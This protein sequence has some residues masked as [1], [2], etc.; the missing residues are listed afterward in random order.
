MKNIGYCKYLRYSIGGRDVFVLFS[1]QQ[2][3]AD[4]TKDL[5][6]SEPVS[7]GMMGIVFGEPSFQLGS[8]TLKMAGDP[9]DKDKFKNMMK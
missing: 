4:I 9:E 6:K 3:H 2:Q 8:M 7:A 1:S 5:A